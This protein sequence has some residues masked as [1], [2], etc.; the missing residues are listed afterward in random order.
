MKS[1]L[2]QA[3]IAKEKLCY[4]VLPPNEFPRD[5][6]AIAVGSLTVQ[7]TRPLNTCAYL[8]CNTVTSQ[9]LNKS[10]E[11]IDYE[12]PLVTFSISA[13]E[14]NEKKMF[15][16]T[17]IWFEMNTKSNEIIFSIKDIFSERL[18]VEDVKIILQVYFQQKC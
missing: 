14:A 5:K 11:I 1:V 6:W 4:K 9:K 8:T 3:N 16:F 7:T 10:F 15:I 12:M 17:P 2:L 18:L 13:T